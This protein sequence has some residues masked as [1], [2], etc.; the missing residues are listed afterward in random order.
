MSIERDLERLTRTID[1]QGGQPTAGQAAMTGCLGLALIIKAVFLLA[2]AIFMC[3]FLWSCADACQ[4]SSAALSSPPSASR[5]ERSGV[6]SGLSTVCRQ[7]RDM[8]AQRPT[9]EAR[10]RRS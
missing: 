10:R 8:S 2:L 1:E 9:R 5:V 7:A 3:W 4:Q 6:G